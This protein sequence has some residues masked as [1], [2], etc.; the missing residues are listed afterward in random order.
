[1]R[2]L[3]IRRTVKKAPFTRC[4]ERLFRGVNAVVAEAFNLGIK[5]LNLGCREIR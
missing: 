3:L 5:V 2:Y 1:M 4:F